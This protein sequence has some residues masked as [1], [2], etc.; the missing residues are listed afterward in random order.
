[1]LQL[2]TVNREAPEYQIQ[3]NISAATFPNP[4]SP[5]RLPPS[6]P[7]PSH[8]VILTINRL[9][10]F[11][12]P[13]A[14]PE[15]HALKAR[16]AP[17]SHLMSTATVEVSENPRAP[18]CELALDASVP[19]PQETASKRIFY[20]WAMLPLSMLVM[21]ATCP[22][23]TFGI[24]YFNAKFR[25]AFDL[26]QTQLSATYLVATVIASLALPYLGGLSDRYGLKRS[27]IMA[28]SALALTCALASQVQGVV[29]LFIMFTLLR[30]IGPGMMSLLANN[31][32]ATWFD[33]RLG[34]VSG[35]MQVAMACAIATVP[36]GIVYLINTFG[37][38][39]AYI[40]LAA[41]LGVGL[42]P[43][44][45]FFY[46]ESPAAFGQLPDGARRHNDE[47][48]E[49]ATWGLDVQQAMQHRAYWILL[50]ATAMWALIGTGLIFHLDAIFQG[51]GLG[52]QQSTRAIGYMAAAMATMQILGGLLADRI[53][54]RWLVVNAVGLIGVSCAMLA[55]QDLRL[56]SASYITYGLG[57]GLMTIIAGTSWAR[58]FGRAHL[59]KIRGTSLTAAIAGSS[60]GPLVMGISTDYLGG[61]APSLWI[62]AGFAG[63]ISIAGFWATPPVKH[64]V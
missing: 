27:I 54:L 30:M 61:F 38:R 4:H 20:G 25:T 55:T 39:G 3:H 52:I 34:M 56:L 9:Y 53:P 23:Q 64:A 51:Y 16:F 28:V 21:I 32:L 37:W 58:Y 15:Q 36:M 59:G 11:F 13:P 50:M 46:R 43:L 42:V 17:Q 44:L 40:A 33:R 6:N 62:F 14:C 48:F 19:L 8:C 10:C 5:L 1:M 41:I 63:I 12:P 22:G 60:L 31:T 18:A 47:Q 45:L 2:F 29:T 57:Q 26:S 35:M 24:T 7:L 49:L